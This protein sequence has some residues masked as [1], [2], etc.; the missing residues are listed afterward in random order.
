MAA[1]TATPIGV[2]RATVTRTTLSASDTL[3]YAKASRMILILD[4]TTG[5]SLS[6][7]ID[8]DGATVVSVPGVGNVDI[9]AGYAVGPIAAGA[10]AAIALDTIS[11]Y[12]A[13]AITI[14]GGTGIKASLLTF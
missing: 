13:G 1:I 6:P 2:G 8:G 3:T 14:T 12:L 10:V 11:A 9:S 7:V 5:G 4:N